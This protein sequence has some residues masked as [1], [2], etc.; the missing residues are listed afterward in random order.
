MFFPSVWT[1]SRRFH[2]AELGWGVVLICCGFYDIF[3]TR[4]G[5]FVYVLLQGIAFLVTGFDYIGT[6]IPT[7]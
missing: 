4:K 5:Y 6:H 1:P 3:V 7:S 2:V